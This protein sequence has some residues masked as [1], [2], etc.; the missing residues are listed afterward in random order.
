[1]WEVGVAA[2]FSSEAHCNSEPSV[3]QMAGTRSELETA[4]NRSFSNIV[5]LT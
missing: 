4:K 5:P 2:F 1:M 3:V